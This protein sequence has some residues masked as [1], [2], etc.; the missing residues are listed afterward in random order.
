MLISM[1][2]LGINAYH[3]DS[4]AALLKDGKIVCAFEEERFTR[5]KHWAGLP[6]IS[7]R[8]CLKDQKIEIQDVDHIVISRNPKANRKQKVLFALKNR[9]AVKALLQRTRNLSRV[10]N[11]KE[12]L[13]LEF[14]IKLEDFIPNVEAI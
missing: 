9:I 6:V 8:E 2:I 5:L 11:I 10:S 12:D 4:S 3:G 7:V 1:F 14:G 13:A